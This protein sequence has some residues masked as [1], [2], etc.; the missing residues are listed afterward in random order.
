LP[1]VAMALAFD[2]AMRWLPTAQSRP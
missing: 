2:A 1:V